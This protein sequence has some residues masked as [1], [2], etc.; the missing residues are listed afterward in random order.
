MKAYKM[1][2]VSC[3]VSGYCYNFFKDNNSMTESQ[4][5][6]SYMHAYASSQKLYWGMVL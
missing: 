5:L 4:N 3:T 1:L 2:W 6:I